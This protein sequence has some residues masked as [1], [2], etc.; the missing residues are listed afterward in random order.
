[1]AQDGN[2][3]EPEVTRKVCAPRPI[4]LQVALEHEM[5]FHFDA[6]GHVTKVTCSCGREGTVEML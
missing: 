3:Q 4:E 2:W 6:S 1:M 5:E